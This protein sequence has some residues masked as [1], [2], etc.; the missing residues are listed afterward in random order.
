MN[1]FDTWGAFLVS[2][3][4]WLIDSSP[5]LGV[6][7]AIL[8]AATALRAILQA[9]KDSDHRSRP[10]VAAEF[11]LSRESDSSMDL[12]VKNY[13]VSM[14]RNLIVS[15]DRPL[16]S[17]SVE[18]EG[19]GGVAIRN[20]YQGRTFSVLSPGQELRNTWWLGN[21]KPKQD[22]LVNYHDTPD[23]VVVT[24]EYSDLKGK[25][26]RDTFSLHV[27]AFL[28]SSEALSS[29]SIRGRLGLIGN[30]LE[31]LGKDSKRLAD[32][33]EF[34]REEALTR[35]IDETIVNRPATLASTTVPQVPIFSET[36]SN[37]SKQ[38][39]QEENT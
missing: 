30:A 19:A 31:G 32:M 27:D 10:V 20:R 16:T 35:P 8:S 39:S 6:L 26:Y 37:L 28:F 3:W 14:A 36:K 22:R 9:A 15:F 29:T 4:N 34:G 25:R 33:V 7:V 21:S 5:I 12:V 23:E 17:E 24:V 2:S 1:N 18:A 38:G 11:Q 13:G